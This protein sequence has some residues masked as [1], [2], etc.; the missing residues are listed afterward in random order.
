L[1]VIVRTLGAS[2]AELASDLGRQAPLVAQLAMT[3]EFVVS[4]DAEKP[5]HSSVIVLPDLEVYVPL[6]GVVDIDKE[7]G[8]LAAAREKSQA[9]L[10]KLSRKLAN[11][12]FLAK[13]APEVVAKTREEADGHARTIE[14]ID[15]QL[16]ELC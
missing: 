6:E 13:A 9:E 12:G 11:E 3:A 15:Q 8:R 14:Q 4:C 1:P 2:A 5:A 10:D 16:K 7:R